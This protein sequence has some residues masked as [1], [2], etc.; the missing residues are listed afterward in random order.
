MSQTMKA[1]RTPDRH[2]VHCLRCHKP[3]ECISVHLARVCMRSSTPEERAA[4]VQSA[5]ASSKGWVRYGRNW[6]YNVI[7]KLI[8]DRCSQANLVNELLRR[9]FFVANQPS[10][11]DAEAPSPTRVVPSGPT[12]NV[13]PPP[14]PCLVFQSKY[15]T[16]LKSGSLMFATCLCQ[17]FVSL[18]PCL[19]SV[20]PSHP[21]VVNPLHLSCFLFCPNRFFLFGIAALK[22]CQTI[23]RVAKPEINRMCQDLEMGRKLGHRESTMYRYYC[24]ATL[25]F[26]H[27]LRPIAVESLTDSD[28]L[29]RFEHSG[30]VVIGVGRGTDTNTLLALTQWEEA[31]LQVYFSKIRP[32][33]ICHEKPCNAFFLV[34]SGEAVSSVSRDLKCLHDLHKLPHFTSQD[35]RRAVGIAAQKLTEPQRQ[36]VQF[37]LDRGARDVGPQD[38]VDAAVLLD[39]LCVTRLKMSS[40]EENDLDLSVEEVIITRINCFEKFAV[41]QI[42]D[43]QQKQKNLEESMNDKMPS[44]MAAVKADLSALRSRVEAQGQQIGEIKRI[45]EEKAT[46]GPSHSEV[47]RKRSA[48]SPDWTPEQKRSRS[49]DLDQILQ[50]FWPEKSDARERLSERQQAF[51]N[52]MMDQLKVKDRRDLQCNAKRVQCEGVSRGVWEEDWAP[53]DIKTSFQKHKLPHF[54]SQDVRRAVGIAAQK[55]TEPQRQAVQFYL[56]RGARDVGP[57][58]AV[59]AAVLLDSLCVNSSDDDHQ[60]FAELATAG[61]SSSLPTARKDF[62]AF[63]TSFPISLDGQPPSKKQRVKYGFPEDRTFY[64]KWRVSQYAQRREYLLEHFKVHKPS[65][66]KLSR[67]I[68]QE[69]WK[70]N[71]PKPEEIQRLWKPSPSNLAIESDEA[72]MKCLSE[73]TW[74]GLAIKDFGAKQGRGVV[75]T[76]PFLKGEIVC[77]YHGKVIP[78]SVG[79]E[80]MRDLG[81]QAGYLFFFK[82]GQRDLCVDAQTFPCTCHPNSDTFG[83]LINH[84]A[85]MPNL[86]PF[87]C[88]VKLSGVKTDVILFKALSDIPVDTQLKFD[89][90]VRRTSFRGEGLNLEWLDE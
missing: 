11:T 28:W 40:S 85:K 83:R 54:T 50:P 88:S 74:T 3:Q 27:M 23:L 89:Y 61:G 86:K 90:G 24:E 45:L 58:D 25:V 84:S 72:I 34:S 82:A 37:Y 46:S 76:R 52:Y 51:F 19:L 16:I 56:D 5:K 71:Y 33:N 44:D 55:L 26:A 69:G 87:Y 80:M 8:P 66:G 15:L 77:D 4:E 73:Q 1:Q 30:R 68:R 49:E 39:S 21:S 17:F 53:E 36:A 6:D 18:Y 81:D 63:V 70:S 78:A 35:V 2:L 42:S 75:A 12:Q 14:Y 7:C 9:G 32:G 47:Q 29:D 48:P 65:T 62:S 57:Q 67:L 13:I 43:L 79:K 31:C 64:D 41:A 38:A 20:M 60:S 22:D 10:E 59:D